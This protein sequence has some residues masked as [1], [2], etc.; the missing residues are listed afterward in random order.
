[1]GGC[2]SAGTFQV[3]IRFLSFGAY[4]ARGPIF[5]LGTSSSI[6]ADE[7][8]SAWSFQKCLGVRNLATTSK[9]RLREG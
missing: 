6:A 5:T 4:E 8:Y 9:E 1:M 3:P 7:E 2:W